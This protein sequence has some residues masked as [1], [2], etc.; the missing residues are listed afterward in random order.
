V[1]PSL[2]PLVRRI[3]LAGLVFF[4]AKGLLWLALVGAGWLVVRI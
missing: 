1:S 2:A 4:T 3:G